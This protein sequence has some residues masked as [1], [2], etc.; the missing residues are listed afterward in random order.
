MQ[1][2]VCFSVGCL[3]IYESVRLTQTGALKIMLIDSCN[4]SII[5]K[6]LYIP[7]VLKIMPA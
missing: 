4:A 3:M 5:L 1:K 7:T 2:L 6:C